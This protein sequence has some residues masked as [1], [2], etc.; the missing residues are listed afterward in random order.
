ML[1]INLLITND[2]HHIE[3]SQLTYNTNQLI[4]FY[5]MG[6]IGRYQVKSEIGRDSYRNP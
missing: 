1:N 4:G 2:L 3:T 6:N 5:M